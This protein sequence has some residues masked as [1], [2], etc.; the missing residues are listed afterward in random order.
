MK[1]AHNRHP[2]VP[3]FIAGKEIS[4]EDVRLAL[5]K[6]SDRLY[7]HPE[8][9]FVLTNLNYADAPW[10]TFPAAHSQAAIW[11]EVGL[12]GSDAHA[13]DQQI[14]QLEPFL[15]D[16]WAAGVNPKTGNPS[17]KQPV[18][19]ILYREDHKFILNS[20]IPRRDSAA[21]NYDLVIASQPF[22]ARASLDFKVKRVLIPLMKSL[23][24]GGR[25]ISIQSHGN[26]PAQE[27]VEKVWPGD[28]PFIH[29]RHMIFAG[30]KKE[31]ADKASDFIFEEDF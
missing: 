28:S 7:E 27:I 26:D 21:A 5:A 1:A 24:L 31:L 13:F 20:S 14:A 8:T 11:H 3:F 25:L 12:K 18:V 29:D 17:Y 22:R 2:H 19:L 9:V 23:G 30:L 6:L 4:L 16:A 10:L 15:A